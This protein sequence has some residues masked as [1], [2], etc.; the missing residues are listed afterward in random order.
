[1]NADSVP[2]CSYEYCRCNRLI[3]AFGSGIITLEECAKN[4]SYFL[5]ECPEDRRDEC[6]ALFCNE[7]ASQ[8][9]KYLETWLEPLDFMPSPVTFI[10]GAP[11]TEEID[12]WKKNLRPHYLN[13][14]E[15]VRK[16]AA[17]RENDK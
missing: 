2:R 1:M 3:S 10:A 17:P 16:R 6:V 12:V 9:L 7:F 5:V 15:L 8:Y 4:L 11:T 13:L 14:V